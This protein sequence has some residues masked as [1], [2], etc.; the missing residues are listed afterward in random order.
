MVIVAVARLPLIVT[1]VFS[2]ADARVADAGDA[3]AY[4]ARRVKLP[5]LIARGANPG[6]DVIARFLG[7]ADGVKSS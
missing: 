3:P 1:L 7:E 5:V 6:A 4:Q 2:V